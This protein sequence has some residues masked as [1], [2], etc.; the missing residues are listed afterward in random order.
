MQLLKLRALSRLTWALAILCPVTSNL[1]MT[2]A[3][4]PGS[5]EKEHYNDQSPISYFISPSK[6]VGESS[7]AQIE[8]R[9]SYEPDFAGFDRSIM[10][11]VSEDPEK[12]DNNIPMI[13]N[14]QQGKT[15]Y[16]I[17]PKE[18]LLGPKS[19]ASG[20]PL[21]FESDA[22]NQSVNEN[23]LGDLA[24]DDSSHNLLKRQD[25]SPESSILY[26]S[27]VICDQP[28]AKDQRPE[29]GDQLSLTVHISQSSNEPNSKFV[30]SNGYGAKSIQSS[31]DVIL[32]VEAAENPNFDGIYNYQLTASIDTLYAAA[33]VSAI[34]DSKDYFM[35]V[36]SDSTSALFVSGNLSIDDT[37][38]A[39]P[40]YSIF[41]YRKDDPKVVGLEQSFCGLQNHVQIKSDLL[42]GPSTAN[43]DTQLVNLSENQ[44][45]QQFYVTGLNAS[46]EYFAVL[47][48]DGN[49]TSDGG[50]VRGGGTV[51]TPLPFITKSG[52]FAALIH[53]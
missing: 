34:N 44:W 13:R 18:Q 17:F 46:S 3:A 15:D 53:E 51:G 7:L 35:R 40:P 16:W 42:N 21:P 39:K 32:G 49:S 37:A 19:A 23:S 6:L 20:T 31:G 26:V 25:G 4:G 38:V 30:T 12:L 10:G 9:H 48:V 41:V 29:T 27:L 22:R 11:R 45:K 50:N 47:A 28:L 33:Y 52:Y 24:V 2:N 1:Q 5:I 36:D 14:I 8:T 43:V